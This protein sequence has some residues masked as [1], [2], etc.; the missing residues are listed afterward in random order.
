MVVNAP[1]FSSGKYLKNTKVF[2]DTPL[3]WNSDERL[4]TQDYDE[5]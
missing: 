4:G 5:R 2:C 1:F 3:E